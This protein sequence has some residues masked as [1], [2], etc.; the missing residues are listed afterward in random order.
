M[1]SWVMLVMVAG[2]MIV[3][4]GTTPYVRPQSI[5]LDRHAA[6]LG[7]RLSVARKLDASAPHWPGCRRRAPSSPTRICFSDR[8]RAV[9]PLLTRP[10]RGQRIVL[11]PAAIVLGWFL[12]PYALHWPSVFAL[13]F[14][15][16][17]GD[18]AP[19]RNQRVQ[20]WVPMV[21]T[22][23]DGSHGGRA[24]A[25][26]PRRGSCHRARREGARALRPSV[27]RGSLLFALAVR[28][29]IVWWLVTIPVVG[30]GVSIVR[31]PTPGRSNRAAC[32]RARDFVLVA[33]A[34]SKPGRIP[35]FAPATAPT[36]YLPF[37]QREDRSNRSRIGSSATRD[38]SDG[39]LVTMFNYGGILPVATAVIL[40]ESID[41]RTIFP[42]SGR[43]AGDLFQSFKS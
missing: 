10:A 42:D 9:R 40:S 14:A 34:G 5:L 30:A 39:R 25:G 13:N 8:P 23:T 17:R 11:V 41:G 36:R 6:G 1:E 27:A 26:L 4:L 28:S 20:A 18:R 12:S 38:L 21:I 19:E 22:A 43:K 2:N 32:D 33:A 7:A 35:R 29:I 16:K 31:T 24:A 37:D 15:P 3:T